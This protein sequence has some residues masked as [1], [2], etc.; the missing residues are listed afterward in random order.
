MYHYIQE[1]KDTKGC[2]KPAPCSGL[3]RYCLKNY[4]GQPLNRFKVNRLVWELGK[5]NPSL[6]YRYELGPEKQVITQK[7]ERPFCNT[8]PSKVLCLSHSA[9]FRSCYYCFNGPC[10]TEFF[11][12]FNISSQLCLWWPPS[13]FPELSRNNTE[14][15]IGV[16]IIYSQ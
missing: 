12:I 2:T 5:V 7:W 3:G 8:L 15:Y 4:L 16:R 13:I 11:G 6:M 14:M 9:T 1:W 10:M